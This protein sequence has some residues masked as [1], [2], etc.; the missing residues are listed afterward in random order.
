MGE[1]LT[2][3]FHSC[4]SFYFKATFVCLFIMS[5]FATERVWRSEAHALE[6]VLT[7]PCGWEGS[8]SGLQAELPAWCFYCHAMLLTHSVAAAAVLRRAVLS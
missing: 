8:D 2:V 5:V 3:Q 1:R 7:P 6:S 4:I